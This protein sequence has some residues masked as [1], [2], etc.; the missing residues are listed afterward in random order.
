MENAQEALQELKDQLEENQKEEQEIIEQQ[1]EDIVEAVEDE[2]EESPVEEVSEDEPEITEDPEEDVDEDSAMKKLR[3]RIESN[4]REKM[5]EKDSEL[6]EVKNVLKEMQLQMAEQKGF[7]DALAKP[8]PVI[9]DPEPDPVLDP[10]EHNAWKIR[11][12]EKENEEFKKVQSEHSS[13]IEEQ[14]DRA[15]VSSLEGDFKRRNPDVDYDAAKEFIKA[16][17]RTILKLQFPDATDAQI[18]SHFD[19]YEMNMFKTLA[20]QGQNATEVIVSMA[21]EYG[22]EPKSSEPSTKKKPNFKALKKNQEKNASL[23]GGSDATKEH[24]V[25]A[26]QLF[27]MSIE[28]LAANP[29]LF[30]KA[31]K[32]IG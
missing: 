24:S 16:R 13:L 15:A 10:E 9:V 14:R 21:K 25:T 30:K 5:K 20:S 11:K 29:E 22:Y 28:Q 4:Y 6:K 7:Q 12:L 18:D 3:K 2:I 19:S 26:E 27:N 17:E 8:D 1:S 31:Y 32:N 23:I